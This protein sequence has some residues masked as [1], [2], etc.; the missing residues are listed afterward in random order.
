MLGAD[1]AAVELRPPAAYSLAG[2]AIELA[3][4][5]GLVLEP[6]QAAGLEV[7]MSV[8]SDGQWAAFEYGELIPRQN[9]KTA[10][11]AVR[12][13]AGL[14]LLGEKLIMWSA[15]EYKT[16]LESFL[17]MQGILEELGEVTGPRRNLIDLG[18]GVIIKV[19]NTNGEEEFTR[20]RMRDPHTGRVLPKQRLKFLAR[21]KGS[22]RGFSGD[23]NLIDEA[24]AYTPAHQSALMPTMTARPNP[25]ICYASSPPLDGESGEVLFALRERVEQGGAAAEGLGWRD[26]G[27]QGID[28]A[29]LAELEP[30]ARDAILDDRARWCATNPALGRG[31]VTEES[32]LRNRRAMKWA[33]F[34]REC[35]GVWPAPPGESGRVIRSTAWAALAAPGSR[36]VG[37]PTPAIDCTPDGTH[38]AIGFGGRRVDVDGDELDGVLVEIV[39]SRPGTG[40]VVARAVELHQ[41]HEPGEW[42]IDPGG[43]AGMLVKPLEAAGIPLRYVTGRDYAGACGDFVAAVKNAKVWHLG[44][45]I[46]DAAVAAG[47]KREIGDGG[48]SWG[49]KNSDANIAPLVVATL[50]HSVASTAIDPMDNIW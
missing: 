48:W 47:R 19:N 17:L 15:H 8:R 39:E 30:D 37:T 7:M 31:R 45:K 22:G 41:R 4:R 18:D 34:A 10:E 6:W 49:R 14:L 32:I 35:E 50:A 16:A 23:V 1:R 28:L 9:G 27:L 11:F 25:Q 21:S 26:F 5:G 46:L 2:P 38:T 3:A 43:P 40:W 44:D 20:L 42:L 13:L 29:E 24:F 12:A 36:L 33:D